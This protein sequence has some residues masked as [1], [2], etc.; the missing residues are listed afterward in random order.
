MQRKAAF[1]SVVN[2]Q[3]S[4]NDNIWVVTVPITEVL[5]VILIPMAIGATDLCF[6][7]LISWYYD[8]ICNRYTPQSSWRETTSSHQTQICPLVTSCLATATTSSVLQI[9]FMLCSVDMMMNSP[10][11]LKNTLRRLVMMNC[12]PQFVYT[13]FIKL[14]SPVSHLQITPTSS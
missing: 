14:L 3:L 7:S 5:I 6:S 1:L 9:S 10:E 8:P 2:S 13:D 11:R 4:F 12:C